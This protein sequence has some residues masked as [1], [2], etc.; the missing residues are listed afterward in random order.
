MLRARPDWHC[1]PMFPHPLQFVVL[2]AI[3]VGVSG[4]ATQTSSHR[5]A[6]AGIRSVAVTYESPKVPGRSGAIASRVARHGAG[7]A[8]GQFGFIGGLVGLGWDI[9]EIATP[10]SG[11]SEISPAA[12]RLLYDAGASPLA[13][14]AQRTEQEIL[15]QRL[16]ALASANPDAVFDLKLRGLQF[17]SADSRGLDCRASLAVA[18]SLHDRKGA[19]LW[20]KEAAA[21]S[22]R[23]RSWRACEEQPRLARGDFEALAAVVARQLLADFSSQSRTRAR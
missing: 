5:Q 8:L 2:L 11:D 22:T 13:L 1:A 6:V 14:V 19:T 7:Y 10:S 4:C 23:S 20:R 17:Q 21:T 12:L 18:A 15:R 3:A 9:A 16:F